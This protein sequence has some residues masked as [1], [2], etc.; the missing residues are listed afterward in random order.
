MVLYHCTSSDAID[1]I[2]AHKELSDVDPFLLVSD[3][4][5]RE[6]APADVVIFYGAPYEFALDDFEVAPSA[7]GERKWM[8]PASMLFEFPHALWPQSP[9]APLWVTIFERATRR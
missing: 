9:L 6:C 3:R 5:P 4:P 8:I 2:A 7:S 1:G